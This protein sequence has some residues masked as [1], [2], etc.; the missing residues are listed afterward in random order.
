[1]A[2]IKRFLRSPD[3]LIPTISF[4][5]LIAICIFITFYNNNKVA[6]RLTAIR[7]AGYPVTYEELDKW[8]PAVPDNDNAAL[9]SSCCGRINALIGS[10]FCKK[11]SVT[12]TM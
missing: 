3:F 1:M 11:K 8:Y 5:I 4:L 9:I 7:A 2:K 12:F 10:F 6:K